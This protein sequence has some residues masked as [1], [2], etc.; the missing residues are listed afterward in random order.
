MSFELTMTF[1]LGLL[2]AVLV[3]VTTIRVQEV[4]RRFDELCQNIRG[5]A[6]LGVQYWVSNAEND[7]VS[8]K[9]LIIGHQHLISLSLQSLA[10]RFDKSRQKDWVGSLEPFI[11]ALTGGNFGERKLELDPNQAQLVQTEMA[12]LIEKVRDYQ[13][14]TLRYRKIIFYIIRQ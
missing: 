7:K 13:K 14:S 12:S 4:I 10:G 3:L 8:N 6:D 5:A 1:F 2:S 11:D 9:A